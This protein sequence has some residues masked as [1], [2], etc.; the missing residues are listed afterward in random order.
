MSNLRVVLPDGPSG[1]VI[2][3]SV[4]GNDGWHA[5]LTTQS[6]SGAEVYDCP[7]TDTS[8]PLALA[9]ACVIFELNLRG[10]LAFH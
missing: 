5:R 4:A 3:E 1:S 6:S 7:S 2:A 10:R 9:R 8:A